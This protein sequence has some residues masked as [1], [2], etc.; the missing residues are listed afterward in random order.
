VTGGA[1]TLAS[2]HSVTQSPAA[3]SAGTKRGSR[4]NTA[5]R[6]GELK[7][8]WRPAYADINRSSRTSQQLCGILPD[9]ITWRVA[10]MTVEDAIAEAIAYTSDPPPNEGTTCLWIIDPLLNAAGYHR[11]D[12]LAR[13]TDNI[14]QFPDYTILQ[15][16]PY[17]WFL[18]AKAWSVNL[19]DR[20]AQQSLNYANQNGK[21]WV[22]LSNGRE[23]RLYDN[24]IQ[25]VAADK[26]VCTIQLENAD[27]LS[28]FLRGIGKA[29]VTSGDLASFAADTRVADILTEQLL[30]E[31]SAAVKALHGFLRRLP[32]LENCPKS[33]VTSF[34]RCSKPSAKLQQQSAP[35]HEA[36]EIKQPPAAPKPASTEL[37]SG[38]AYSL[39]ELRADAIGL[40]TGRKPKEVIFPDG[41]TAPTR[42]WS[43]VAEEVL[44]YLSSR[45]KLPPLPYAA[46]LTGKRYFLNSTAVHSNG[47]TMTVAW[48]IPSDQGEA[49]AEL[50]ASG[51]DLVTRLCVLLKDVGFSSSEFKVTLEPRR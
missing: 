40:V 46:G 25:G 29:S 43:I 6:S 14:G 50:H 28:K 15:D 12:I 4:S 39:E 18:E 11:R 51:A 19:E 49:H 32:G 1:L 42:Y 16:S 36:A 48:R 30:D 24:L 45:G 17:C 7:L 31:N 26:L 8:S 38:G 13:G 20:H 21:R 23:W 3:C 47:K 22:V 37:N 2:L 35:V 34:F 9:H 33:A 44:K 10:N 41:T 5:R 27:G